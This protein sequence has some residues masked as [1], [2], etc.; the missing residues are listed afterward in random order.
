MSTTDGGGR[1]DLVI[2]NG[3]IATAG[4]VFRCDIGIRSGRIVALGDDLGPAE[5][6]IDATGKLVTPGGVDSHCHMD[7]QP[8]E[9]QVTCDDFRSGTISAACGG[10]S[11]PS[12]T[13]TSGSTTLTHA[14]RRS[15]TSCTS[16][17]ST[18]SRVGS[19]TRWPSS[20]M[21]R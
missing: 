18:C 10:T 6:I 14:T 2:R 4:D 15:S 5:E 20:D 1:F 21:S 7:Q 11:T 17:W 16:A 12:A 13:A 19:P 9:G 8:W 3:L